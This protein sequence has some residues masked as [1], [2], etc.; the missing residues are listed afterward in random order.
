MKKNVQEI[1]KDRIL[2]LDGAM[3]TMIQRYKLA[4]EDYRGTRFRDHSSSLKG[5]NDLLV[6]T[7]PD[8]IR[9]IHKKYLES[10]A[11]IIE[12]NT[13]NAQRVSLSDY[14]ME[15][16]AYE[17][18]FEA[19]KIAK[20]AIA[21]FSTPEKPRFV[22]GSIG[23]TN[24]T[25]SLSPDVNNPA[26][27]NVNYDEL[28][29]AYSEQIKGLIDGG[30][31]I[32]LIET[33]F[34]TLNAKAALYA[35]EEVF[36][37]KNIRLPIM[38]SVTITDNAGRTLS[39]QT[40]EAFL[41][42]FS[43]ADLF[44]IGLNCAFGA[45]QIEPYL[46]ELSRKAPCYVSVYPNAGLPNQFGEY[47]ES[48]EEMA[49]TVSTFAKKGL[50]NIVG[51]C[52]G[53]TPRHIN[54]IANEVKA[55]SPRIAPVLE[56][57]TRLS[58]LESLVIRKE[59]NF[60][61][62]G[63]RTNVSGSMKFA[64]L[65]REHKYEEALLVARQQ[66]ENGAQ[67]FDVSLDDG[68]ID[69]ETE[70][71]LF[72]RWI[73]SDPDVAKVPIM[74][75]SSRWSVLESSLKSVQGKVIVNSI[76]L[77]EGEEVFLERA[78][79]IRQ[80]GAAAIVMA[81]D[82]DGQATT[83]QRKIDV[84][85]RA[86]DLLAQKINFP[87]EDIIFDANI[88]TIG[89][90]L[91]EHNNFAI[92]FLDAIKWI[93]EN[94][95]Y[96]KTSGGISNLSFSFRGNEAI[97]QV[98]HSV[99]LYHAI[100]AG[101][102]MGIVNAGALPV[103]DQ[104]DEKIKTLAEDLIFNRR[105]DATERILEAALNLKSELVSDT[106]INEWR[107]LPVQERLAHALV[108]G[109]ADFIDEDIAEMLKVLPQPIDI[110]EGPLMTGMSKVGDLFGSGQMFLPQVMK[111][112]RVMKKA[113]ALLQPL[114]EQQSF[115]ANSSKAGKIL[116][117]TV[118]GD[119]HDIG[120]NIAGII[121][122]CNNYEII[123]L[124]I[125]VP[126]ETILNEAERLNVNLVGLSGLI[127]P[128]LDEMIYVAKGMEERGMK[129][130]LLIGGATTSKI[131]TAVKIAQAYSGAVVHVKDAS[132]SA[133]IVSDLLNSEKKNE[134]L[135]KLYSEYEELKNNHLKRV[136]NKKEISE[137]EAFANRFKFDVSKADI[138]KPAVL[139]TK[140]IK[141]IPVKEL[142]PLISWA[143][144][145]HQWQFKGAYPALFDDPEK[146]KE[147]KQLLKDARHLLDKIADENLLTADAVFGIF[148]AYS[149]GNNIYYNAS[150]N[151]FKKIEFP[152]NHEQ[153]ENNQSN[154]CLSDF[155]APKELNTT[156]YIGM[157]VTT[158]GMGAG[159]IEKQF[160]DAGDEYSALM[161]RILADRLAE[162][163]AEYLHKKIRKEFWAYSPAENI[164]I[165]DML[166]EK[167]R[168]IRPAPGYPSCPE[169]KLKS[170]IF[171]ELNVTNNI[172]A[173]LTESYSMIPAATVS[174]FYFAHPE[175][176]YFGT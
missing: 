109:I 71:P 160:K 68:M 131:H 24:K 164:N 119:V 126:R 103:Y 13:F 122:A 85:K 34:D 32:I 64:K 8:V 151:G 127:T 84:C 107:T 62:I 56:P 15:S 113:V 44:S 72:L 3:G 99:F 173:S 169:H 17:I 168:G 156:D 167:Y 10:G 136:E 61:N 73:S 101:L 57:L 125:M 134:Y 146:G 60:I 11:D 129:I 35:T 176:R 23:P 38:I 19:A 53:T 49:K 27:R 144:F 50:V 106:G 46:E 105:A 39:G 5:N 40:L 158:T 6:L 98:L 82:E 36:N 104:I 22:A 159:K 95:P 175:A 63:E 4:E 67:I 30:A 97:R 120:K 89:T 91:A 111:S 86:Y 14:K 83:Y 174:G 93:K 41:I 172:G 65:I 171:N 88:L 138:I 162:A 55:Y 147:A 135:K 2:I 80:Y 21:K 58:G 29:I 118:K 116:I 110:I 124:G 33:I 7:K 115:S 108:K 96:A 48:A 37:E 26:A 163:L 66:I 43:H 133:G 16:L 157:F 9:E 51:G 145:F 75:D 149:D 128:S 1:I 54:A 28:V 69:A 47:D 12:T 79:K 142:I 141:N 121:L 152:R 170:I 117:A 165:E 74:I 77:K 114:L 78:K 112:A 76:S 155:I 123:D 137:K 143:Y 92:E 18:N 70:M 139:G 31:D 20:Q 59:S 132:L 166:K 150:A 130:P 45:K 42:S 87:P 100:K 102:D 25:A 140:V 90:G 81:F 94:L 52:C 161:V 148:P 154:L 153:K